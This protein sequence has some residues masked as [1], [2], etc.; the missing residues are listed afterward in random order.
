MIRIPRALRLPLLV[1]GLL[2]LDC[3]LGPLALWLVLGGG[4]RDKWPPDRPVEW[5]VAGAIIASA[6]ALF[7]ACLTVRW[8]YPRAGRGEGG[9]GVE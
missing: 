1:L 6:A 5:V 4:A 8:W 2:T 3:F 9:P 7:V